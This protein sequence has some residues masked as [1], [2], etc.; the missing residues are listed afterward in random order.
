MSYAQLEVLEN[1]PKG[2]YFYIGGPGELDKDMI[3]A[4]KNSVM[5]PCD[6][7]DEKYVVKILI[8]ADLTINYVKDFDTVNINKNKCAYD[9]SRKIMPSLKRWIPAK[10]GGI[11]VGAIVDVLIDPFFLYYSKED[12]KDNKK[13]SAEF[14][15]G[16]K[17]FAFQIESIAEK[18]I[19]L[20]QDKKTFITFVINEEG[21]MEDFV[22]VGDYSDLEKQ[23][24]IR[25]LSRISGGWEPASFNDIPVKSKINQFIRQ[26]FSPQIEKDKLYLNERNFRSR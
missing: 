14:K 12:P 15:K 8:K 9:F 4:V 26:E 10:E 2:Q 20:N 25:D 11:P 18:Y 16:K 23:N 13:T 5:S 22:V 21:I 17:N 19:N 24:M 1:Y 6:K 3:K 7:K